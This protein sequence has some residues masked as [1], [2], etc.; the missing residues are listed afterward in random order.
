MVPV[1]SIWFGFKVFVLLKANIK[2]NQEYIVFGKPSLFNGK[3]NIPHPEIDPYLGESERPE[4][5]MAMYNT[6]EKMKNHFLNSR[7]MQKIIEN[8]LGLIK[9]PLPE[10]FH[11]C[12]A[13]SKFDAFPRCC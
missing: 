13:N 6:T 12:R 5:L 11:R 8:A 10:Y 9:D 1:L 4:G 3:W 2:F 7:A